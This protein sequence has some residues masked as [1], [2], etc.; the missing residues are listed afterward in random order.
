MS[1][2][3]CGGGGGGG[4]GQGKC[5]MDNSRKS[6]SFIC[7]FHDSHNMKLKIASEIPETAF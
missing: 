3:K 6:I 7:Y 2:A 5:I 1:Y 4:G